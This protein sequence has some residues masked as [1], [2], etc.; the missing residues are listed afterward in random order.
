MNVIK[1]LAT[2]DSKKSGFIFYCLTG[3]LMMVI[4]LWTALGHDKLLIIQILFMV[5]MLVANSAGSIRIWLNYILTVSLL[6]L[7]ILAVGQVHW[8]ISSDGAVAGLINSFW[9][10]IMLFISGIMLYLNIYSSYIRK[11]I[12]IC[13]M[14]FALM[15]IIMSNCIG[16]SISKG[17]IDAG[18]ITP[19]PGKQ[20]CILSSINKNYALTA[21]ENTGEL[22][23]QRYKGRDSQL[24]TFEMSDTSS[25]NIDTINGRT[26][27]VQYA[28]MEPGSKVVIYEK[29]N[30]QYQRWYIIYFEDETVALVTEIGT[31]PMEVQLTD[32][33]SGSDVRLGEWNQSF[34]Q[35]FIIEEYNDE[36]SLS[37]ILAKHMSLKYRKY[38]FVFSICLCIL[39]ICTNC[40]L[41]TAQVQS[42][43]E[44]MKPNIDTVVKRKKR[45]KHKR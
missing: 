21:N 17:E 39:S 19:E 11:N 43:K 34:E 32:T 44:E 2:T 1:N 14:V 9:L 25:Y 24:F 23:L 26:F 6:V 42:N 33:I 36:N 5:A 41:A 29:L 4:T 38:Y 12:L 7:E 22:T 18:V 20:Y 8:N 10:D 16:S 13:P 40:I 28:V 15:L 30:N 45:K 3:I 37:D 31:I 27:D 35:R